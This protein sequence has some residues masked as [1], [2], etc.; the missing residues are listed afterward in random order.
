MQISLEQLKSLLETLEKGD[1]SEF[2]YEDEQLKLRLSL[3]KKAAALV[4]AAPPVFAAAPASTGGSGSAKATDDADPNVVFVTSP[5]VGT[6]YRA[7]GPDS[8]NFC[9]VGTQVKQGQALCIIEA[10][11][12]MNEI[13]SDSAGTVLDILVENGKSVEFGQKLFKLKKG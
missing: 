9:E 5:F 3:G 7:P 1:V 2:E 12:L 6:F 8:A 11:K 4:Q 10:M 13:E